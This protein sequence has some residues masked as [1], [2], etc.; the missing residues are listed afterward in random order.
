MYCIVFT[1]TNFVRHYINL[2]IIDN[3][4]ILIYG[5]GNYFNAEYVTPAFTILVYLTRNIH[6][7][8]RI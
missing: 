5:L 7:L 4:I 1:N 3:D 2:V 6:M 8:R